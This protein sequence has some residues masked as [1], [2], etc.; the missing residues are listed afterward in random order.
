MTTRVAVVGAG[1]IG[2][3]WAIAFAR[4]GYEVAL[5]EPVAGRRDAARAEIASRLADLDE[6]QL[7]GEPSARV[8]AR[9]G[10]T[11]DL[12]AAVARADYVQES[13]PEDESLKRSVFAQLDGLARPE[14]VLASSSSAIPCSKLAA[15]LP[16]RSRCLVAHPANPPYLL[17]VVELVP[18]PF[19]AERTVTRAAAVLSEAGLGVVRVRREVEGFV[20]NRLQ[21]ALLREAYC[22]VRDG[23]VGVEDLDRLVRDGLGRRWSVVGPFETVDLNTRGGIEA[24]AARMG[25]AYERMGAER[26][27][28]DPW[29]P[30]LVQR[31]AR[32]RRALLPL[33]RWQER[34]EWRDRELMKLERARSGPP[35]AADPARSADRV[36]IGALLSRYCRMLDSMDLDLV[37]TLFTRDCLVEYGPDER[38]R[39]RG[40]E[41]L[42]AALERLHRFARTSHHVSNVEIVFTGPRSAEARSYVLAWHQEPDGSSRTLYGE[43]RDRLL[44]TPEGW[45]IAERR[46][47]TH[48]SDVPW[49]LPL[50]PA[51]RRARP[52]PSG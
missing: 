52:A 27:Q 32:E 37:E 16:G 13:V 36:E 20:F 35:V 45:R 33:D 31:V 18:A 8:C 40:V 15:E 24:H 28:H 14:T 25:P 47:V 11:D 41:R 23:V 43:Y 21:G 46:Q 48:G 44:R 19:T 9:V 17:P 1:S 42:R 5:V 49:D 6:L 22:L 12:E 50:T 26:G 4:A 39:S 34:V 7:L 30:E 3:G 10:A 2:V 29:T 51:E 38:M